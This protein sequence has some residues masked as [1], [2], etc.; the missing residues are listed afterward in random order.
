[1]WSTRWAQSTLSAVSGRDMTRQVRLPDAYVSYLR[2]ANAPV[3]ISIR[4]VADLVDLLHT[5]VLG[6]ALDD[7]V[8]FIHSD[9]AV[10]FLREW[11][12]KKRRLANAKAESGG[13]E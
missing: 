7:L 8:Q 13:E 11:E 4:E 6:E 1:M 12:G 2:V 9:I 3:A 5:K 10:T